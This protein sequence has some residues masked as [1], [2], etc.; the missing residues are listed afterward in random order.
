MYLHI[1]EEIMVRASEVVAIFDKRLL[2]TEWKE[3]L[4][5]NSL[6][7][8]KNISK[9]NIKSIVVTTEYIY[10]SPLASTT[11]KK[12]LDEPPMSESVSNIGIS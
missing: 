5:A 6:E 3:T 12:R 7:K 9:N 2:K 1:G 4:T 11:L 8:I 10:L